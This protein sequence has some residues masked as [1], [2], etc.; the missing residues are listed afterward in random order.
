M[1]KRFL[2]LR[3]R[4]ARARARLHLPLLWTAIV[5]VT[6]LTATGVLLLG[7]QATA[8]SSC[9]VERYEEMPQL[10]PETLPREGPLGSELVGY[11]RTAG[12]DPTIFL[13]NYYNALTNTWTF[14]PNGG[15]KIS[16][17]LQA[18]G[19]K[20]DEP[21]MW[22]QVLQA[23]QYVDRYG[24]EK[25]G[26]FLAPEGLSFA[27][28]SLPPSSLN[29][30][31]AWSC[32]YHSYQVIKPFA[33]NAGPIAPGFGQPGGGLQFQ[34][35]AALIAIP[36]VPNQTPADTLDVLWLVENGYLARA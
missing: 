28:R 20:K 2:V 26:T 7:A 22:E 16:P 3:R 14:P 32:N 8:S 34:L 6:A 27:A 21:I 15:Y 13:A 17:Q 11:D 24:A 10:G 12:Q 19:T 29:G 33:V 23:G 31:P 4:A 1:N 25:R 30:D 18:D 36:P 35:N 9:S 5:V